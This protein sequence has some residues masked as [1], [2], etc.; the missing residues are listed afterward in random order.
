MGLALGMTIKFYT[1]VT[2]ELR[3]EKFMRVRKFR[4]LI[5]RFVEV[6]EKNWWGLFWPKPPSS[7]RGLR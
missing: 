4:G 1:I 7:S 2:K 6:N 3:V 5:H